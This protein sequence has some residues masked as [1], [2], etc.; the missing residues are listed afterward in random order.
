MAENEVVALEFQQNGDVISVKGQVIELL[1]NTKYRVKLPNNAIV[2]AHTSGKMRKNRIKI[3]QYD[4]VN[5]EIS[6]S[7]LENL[8]RK[9]IITNGRITF[10]YKA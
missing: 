4:S 7:D 3:L 10:R 6:I 1:P 9:D 5:V 8:K 2:L